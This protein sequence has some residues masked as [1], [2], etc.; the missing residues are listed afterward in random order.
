MSEPPPRAGTAPGSRVL[1]VLFVAAVLLSGLHFY[2]IRNVLDFNDENDHT[3]IA[4]LLTQGETLYGSVFSHHMPLPYLLAHS[5]AAIS[6]TDRPAQ[7]RIIPWLACLAVALAL[8]RS[9]LGRLD[10]R[11]G[12]AAASAFLVV[13]SIALPPFW[14]HLL[15]QDN[16]AGCGLAVFGACVLLPAL[17]GVPR[18]PA[19]D[20]VGGFAAGF[21]CTASPMVLWPLLAA[22]VAV[23]VSMRRAERPLRSLFVTGVRIATGAVTAGLLVL[24]W[25]ARF[26]NFAGLVR[27][28]LEFNRRAYAPFAVGGT[29]SITTLLLRLFEEWIGLLTGSGPGVGSGAIR[30]ATLA[31]VWLA[32]GTVAAVARLA[33]RVSGHAVEAASGI[34]L[35]LYFCRMRGFDFH[36]L[37]F[38]ICVIAIGSLAGA[39][40]LVVRPVLLSRAA[41]AVFVGPL[42]V[43]CARNGVN[44]AWGR[45]RSSYPPQLLPIADFLRENTR[46]EERIAAFPLAP[47]LYLESRRRPA[48]DSVY[49]LPW[50]AR[51]EEQHPDLP[52]TC[53]QFRRASPRFVYLRPE[54]IWG[55]FAWK[56]FA[57]CLDAAIRD[58]YRS[59]PDP[60]FGGLLWKRLDRSD[61]APETSGAAFP[62][63]PAGR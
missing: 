51:W 23:G 22:A 18:R 45:G 11:F 32:A 36:A 17:V 37:P 13:A 26:G 34:A 5:V 52:T 38:F 42:L 31:F 49:F 48:T 59:L 16:L 39:C 41:V 44:Q 21:A 8:V 63:P 2:L 62:G 1:P 35:Y 61:G 6:P 28:V 46:P 47:R 3:T 54:T 12:W 27:D 24:L 7:F 25:I 58:R 33:S 43:L 29:S 56:D 53:E 9:P 60:R 40:L 55:L 14:G 57:P 19:D 15:L 4:W 20:L 30:L 50:Q 10:S